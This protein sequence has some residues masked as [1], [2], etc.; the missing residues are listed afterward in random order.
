M[1]QCERVA[2][3]GHVVVDQNG[4]GAHRPLQ[5]RSQL[6]IPG[7][8]EVPYPRGSADIAERCANPASD[9]CLTD[10]QKDRH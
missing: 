5:R 3:G 6:G 9:G 4:S 1:G 7:R 10:D 8:D 2:E